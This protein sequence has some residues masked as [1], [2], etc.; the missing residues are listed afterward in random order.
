MSSA[1]DQEHDDLPA[2]LKADLLRTFARSVDVPRSI[3]DAIRNRAVAKLAGRSRRTLVIRWA[4]VMAAAAV[5]L[6]AIKVASPPA[7]LP[8]RVASANDLNGDGSVNVLDALILA[9]KLETNQSTVDAN[10]DGHVD[11]SD[12]DAIAMIAV[13]LDRGATP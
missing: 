4:S 8:V 10:G 1:T 5:I 9:K 12:V 7:S 13:R 2:N 11:R 3:D 6:F